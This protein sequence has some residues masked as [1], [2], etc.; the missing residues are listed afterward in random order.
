MANTG[1]TNAGAANLEN[2]ESV[3]IVSVQAKDLWI[4]NNLLAD[5]G[6]SKIKGYITRDKKGTFYNKYIAT[7]DYSL[8]RIQLER[9]CNQDGVQFSFPNQKSEKH[10][11][12]HY[13]DKVISVDFDLTV[14]DYNKSGDVFVKYGYCYNKADYKKIDKNDCI[15][16][17]KDENGNDALIGIKLNTKVKNPLSLEELKRLGEYFTL[18][19]IQPKEKEGKKKEKPYFVYTTTNKDSKRLY[20]IKAIRDGLYTKGFVCNGRTYVR[21]KRSAGKSRVGKCLF[22]D[23]TLYKKIRKWELCGLKVK[24]N[25]KIDLA[26]FESYIALSNSSIIDTLHIKKENILIIPE[27]ESIFKEKVIAVGKDN[28]KRLVAEEK[29]LEIK[30]NIWDGQSLIDPLLM[31]QYKKYGSVLL[32]NRFYKSCAFTCDIQKFFKDKGIADVSQLNGFTLATEIKDIKYITTESSI[33]YSKF[34]SKKSG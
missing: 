33:K 16:I 32:R 3:Y 17:E 2:K 11:L 5:E 4:A 12:K 24:E 18:K 31:K 20:N 29:T 13:C 25:D 15:H 28:K 19:E 22:I 21:W 1:V 9:I 14:K 34:G 6:K 8:D 26:A 27:Y 30:N 7:L 10:K 23:K